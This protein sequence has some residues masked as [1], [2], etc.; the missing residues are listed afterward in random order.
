M[1]QT[2]RN[3][4]FNY[5]YEEHG[6]LLTSEEIDEIINRVSK[7]EKLDF[8]QVYGQRVNVYRMINVVIFCLLNL[9]FPSK[10]IET[11]VWIFVA[12]NIIHV[13]YSMIKRRK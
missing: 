4:L 12:Y 8:E 10:A 13:I 6:V 3:D 2:E 11:I 9:I 1:K 5:F 7:S